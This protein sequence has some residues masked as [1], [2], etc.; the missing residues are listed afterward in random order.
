MADSAKVKQNL[1]RKHEVG[2]SDSDEECKIFNVYI[3]KLIVNHC[4]D[5]LAS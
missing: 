2:D 1:K 5:K 4:S 3:N